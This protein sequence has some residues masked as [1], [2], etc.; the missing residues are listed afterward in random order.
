MH[1]C[2]EGVHISVCICSYKRPELLRRTLHGLSMQEVGEEL[3]D[4]TFGVVVCDND[5]NESARAVV[6]EFSPGFAQAIEYCVEPRRGIA[7][8]RNA[9]LKHST[10]RFVAFIDDD[11]IPHK[12]W[13]S[14][15]YR[16]LMVDEA[17]AGVLGPVHPI[18]DERP[19][20]WIVKGRL[21]ERPEH[22]TGVSI[23]P[24]ECRT[25]N[26]LLRRSAVDG[27]E[28]AFRSEFVT[29]SDADFFL[30]LASQGYRFT[31]CN[32][33]A[34]EEVV[35][36]SRWRRSFMIRRGLLRGAHHQGPP[37]DIVRSFVAVP[38]YLVML[39]FLQIA[40][41]HHFMRYLIK[42]SDH[43]GRLLGTLNIRLVSEREV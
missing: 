7:H 33:A 8:A 16:A 23:G 15:L 4:L 35:P 43:V 18:F 24:R 20:A 5:P 27:L 34:V 6:D 38:A 3:Q 9:S 26:V 12:D 37:S 30:R 36:P 32:E 28:P 1:T 41:H 21:C 11:E 22:Q 29:G 42:L 25:G 10:G 14:T 40:G 19:P 2:V 13:L 39:P 17:V 31:W